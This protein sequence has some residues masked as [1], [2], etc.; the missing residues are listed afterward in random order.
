MANEQNSMVFKFTD[1]NVNQ[2]DFANLNIRIIKDYDLS[3]AT[4]ILNKNNCL[5][6]IPNSTNSSYKI[7]AI[8]FSPTGIIKQVLGINIDKVN[9]LYTINNLHIV[10]VYPYISNSG[11]QPTP[12]SLVVELNS[13]NSPITDKLFIYI[14]INNVSGSNTPNAML[15]TILE[16]DL[17]DGLKINFGSVP[18]DRRYLNNI[19]PEN[20]KYYCHKF[21]DINGINITNIFFDSYTLYYK[22]SINLSTILGAVSENNGNNY[23][24]SANTN[25]KDSTISGEICYKA[26]QI[27]D[28]NKYINYVSPDSIQSSSI[29]SLNNDIYIDCQPVDLIEPDKNSKTYI[30]QNKDT[31]IFNQLIMGGSIYIIFGMII[32]LIIY[33]IYNKLPNLLKPTATMTIPT[34]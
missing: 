26:S 28:I 13:Y 30:H 29:S 16:K 22:S 20:Q 8:T 9:T 17:S 18:K 11:N 5:N 32:L 21:K 34:R 10:P 7:P 2:R 27:P 14:N 1:S 33:F 6:F 31:D 15:N 23:Y 3:G 24:S 12:Y 25:L 4:V 19:I